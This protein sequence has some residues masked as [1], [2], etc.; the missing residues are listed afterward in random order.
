MMRSVWEGLGC[1][2]AC[3]GDF[4]ACVTVVLAGEAED[5]ALTHFHSLLLSQ[6]RASKMAGGGGGESVAGG[7]PGVLER[8]GC[9]RWRG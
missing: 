3:A 7:Y 2:V 4:E 5:L 9:G 6:R 1:P 8:G